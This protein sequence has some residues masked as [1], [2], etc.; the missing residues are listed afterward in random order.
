[1]PVSIRCYGYCTAVIGWCLMLCHTLYNPSPAWSKQWPSITSAVRLCPLPTSSE[2]PLRWG[3]EPPCTVPLACWCAFKWKVGVLPLSKEL[4][5]LLHWQ[6]CVSNPHSGGSL[7]PIGVQWNVSFCTCGPA[8]LEPFL[9]THSC[10]AFTAYYKWLSIV[11]RKCPWKQ[12]ARSSTNR[13]PKMSLVIQEGSSFNNLM[14]T[15]Y[16]EKFLINGILLLWCHACDK[17]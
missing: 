15:K 5:W 7:S 8:N 13:A 9:V 14:I 11:S 6:K 10:M 1:M 3:W 17:L 16:D 4:R 12:I 2:R